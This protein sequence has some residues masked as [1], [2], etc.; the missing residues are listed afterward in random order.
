[1]NREM[2]KLFFD[3][4]AQTRKIWKKRNKYYH[5]L[6]E[7]YCKFYIPADREIVELGCGP[8]DLLASLS[9]KRGLGVDFSSEMIKIAEKDHPH[10]QFIC[11]DIEEM[12]TNRPFDYVVMS[13]V[14]SSLWDVQKAFKQMPQLCSDR[15]RIVI[16]FY[17]FL[18]EPIIKLGEFLHLK[19]KQPASNWLAVDDVRGLLQLAGF[20]L[21]KVDRKILLPKFIPFL[22]AFVNKYI[23]NLPL[24]NSLCLVN[25][26]IA[27]RRKSRAAEAKTVSIV[28]PAKNEY[29][30]IEDAIKRIP[31][32]A[33]KQEIIFVEGNSGDNTYEEM[34]RVQQLYPN[35]EIIV[36]RQSGSGKANAVWEGFD[37]A[38]GEI[39]MI[40]DA[41][42]TTPPEDL[43]KFYDAIIGGHGEFINGC[44]LLYPLEDEAMRLLNLMANK[45]F[46]WVFSY[47]LGQRLK[48]TLC[49]TKVLSAADYRAIQA[50]RHY[51]GDFDPFGDFDLLFGAA[52]LSLQIKEVPVRYRRRQYGETQISRFK[53]GWLLLRMSLLA[54]N[55]IKFI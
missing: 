54:S 45:I 50:N 20:E 38:R 40:L 26:L 42:L 55:R 28:I 23:A 24:I 8:G 10:L 9:P 13:D 7:K 53:H 46:S 2:L 5:R 36:L 3:E 18:W 25:I 14:I 37:R 44:R 39:L 12:T 32:F 30:N 34:L 47:L 49:G 27:C 43:V 41:D 29:G 52:K 1:M 15:T 22:S 6:I 17:N 19:L 35:K 51:F 11:E 4:S 16:T 33:P 31:D 21:I 48:D